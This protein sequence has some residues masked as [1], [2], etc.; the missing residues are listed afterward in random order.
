MPEY[1]WIID[2]DVCGHEWQVPVQRGE[3]DETCP[4]CGSTLVMDGEDVLYQMT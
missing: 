3:H 1:Y 2:C 4:E